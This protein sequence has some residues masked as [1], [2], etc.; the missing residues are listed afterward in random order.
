MLS[1]VVLLHSHG[2][3]QT[4]MSEA[5]DELARISHANTALRTQYIANGEHITNLMRNGGIESWGH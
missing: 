3:M 1:T 2:L 5:Y 4:A